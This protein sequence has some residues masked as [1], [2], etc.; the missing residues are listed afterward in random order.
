MENT[1]TEENYKMKKIRTLLSQSFNP[2]INHCL[3][4]SVLPEKIWAY[5]L[6]HSPKWIIL[7]AMFYNMHFSLNN[8]SCH[9]V[10]ISTW[11]LPFSFCSYKQYF[12][13]Y[14]CTHRLMLHVF[15]VTLP[16]SQ[17]SNYSRQSIP[18]VWWG[19]I[20]LISVIHFGS[21]RKFPETLLFIPTGSQKQPEMT[22]E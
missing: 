10:F 16:Q 2:K 18:A 9:Y 3:C 17:S 6:L 21:F 12:S 8:I 20:N 13:D 7:Y 15:N 22:F 14:L 19:K 5:I 11:W 1:N 4:F